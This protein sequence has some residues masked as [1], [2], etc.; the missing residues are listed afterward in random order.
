MHPD[1]KLKRLLD[2]FDLC[3]V[4][5]HDDP[6]RV[7]SIKV[8]IAL[9]VRAEHNSQIRRDVSELAVAEFQVRLCLHA[10]LVSQA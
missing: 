2:I 5:I 6:H 4:H 10:Q 9:V 3:V 1:K 8:G 7:Q